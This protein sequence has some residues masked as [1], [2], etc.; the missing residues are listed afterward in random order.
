MKE[1]GNETKQHTNLHGTRSN[2][3]KQ[4]Q[5][6]PPAVADTVAATAET[7]LGGIVLTEVRG[8]IGRGGVPVVAVKTHFRSRTHAFGFMVGSS[9]VCVAVWHRLCFR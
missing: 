5:Q 9:R 1:Q 6:A 3:G 2:S 7:H 8:G 4:Q